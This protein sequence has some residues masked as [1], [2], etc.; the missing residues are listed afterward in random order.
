MIRGPRINVSSMPYFLDKEGDSTKRIVTAANI[1]ITMPCNCA[2]AAISRLACCC[3]MLRSVWTFSNIVIKNTNKCEW[4]PGHTDLRTL[5]V[6]SSNLWILWFRI[7]VFSEATISSQGL[8]CRL[9]LDLCFL[10]FDHRASLL[11]MAC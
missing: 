6:S 8:A 3:L 11:V 9:P 5:C 7:S 2:E 1:A 4:R 10:L